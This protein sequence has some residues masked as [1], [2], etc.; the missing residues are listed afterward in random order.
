LQHVFTFTL[1][2]KTATRSQNK[3]SIAL[4]KL[5]RL[6]FCHKVCIV[7]GKMMMMMIK[8]TMQLYQYQYCKYSLIGTD[9]RITENPIFVPIKQKTTADIFTHITSPISI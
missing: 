1:H 4:A 6:C 2:S 7:L 8:L 3:Y 5:S 9:E